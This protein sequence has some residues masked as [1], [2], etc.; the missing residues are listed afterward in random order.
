[1]RE[2]NGKNGDAPCGNR[3]PAAADNARACPLDSNATRHKSANARRDGGQR[4]SV[5]RSCAANR[6][7]SHADWR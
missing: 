6:P 2:A 5:R 4:E 3:D 7:E 1:M